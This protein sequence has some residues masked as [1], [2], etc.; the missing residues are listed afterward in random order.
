M[1]EDASKKDAVRAISANIT[2]L[3]LA[4]SFIKEELKMRLTDQ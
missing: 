1:Q 4:K 2:P 3:Q